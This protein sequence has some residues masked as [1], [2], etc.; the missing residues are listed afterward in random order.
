[1]AFVGISSD[2]KNSVAK[3]ID[4]MESAEKR[5]L[6]P[7]PRNSTVITGE[8]P[9]IQD[10]IWGEH[11]HFMDIIPNSWIFKPE[12][13][14]LYV[15]FSWSEGS[16]KEVNSTYVARIKSSNKKFNLPPDLRDS[17]G[18]PNVYLGFRKDESVPPE[19]EALKTYRQKEQEIKDRWRK[20][21]HQV[22]DFIEN[23]KSLN[24]AL[25]LWPDLKVYIPNDYIER[26]ERKANR[27]TAST[28]RAAQI[29]AEIDTNEVQA[30]AVIARLSGAKI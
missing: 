4:D 10:Q 21:K 18:S 28:S 8:E 7:D 11:K 5:Q 22:V 26:I 16:S 1:M 23:C 27:P 24:E 12:S 3:K 2:L 19:L 15:N 14:D 6:G 30:A 9:W 29:L 25:K 17:Y 20:V 13:I